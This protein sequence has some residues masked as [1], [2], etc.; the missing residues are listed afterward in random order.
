MYYT[1]GPILDGRVLLLLFFCMIHLVDLLC[2][3]KKAHLVGKVLPL[4]VANVEEGDWCVKFS[5]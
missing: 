4:L 1:I 5:L 3:E 2:H